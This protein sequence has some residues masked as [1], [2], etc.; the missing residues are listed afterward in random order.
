MDEEQSAALRA[1]VDACL[2]GQDSTASD[3]AYN[4]HKCYYETQTQHTDSV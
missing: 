4:M 2:D 1:L 3:F